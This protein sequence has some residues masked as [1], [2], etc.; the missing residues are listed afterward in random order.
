MNWAKVAEATGLKNGATALARFGQIKKRIG[1]TSGAASAAPGSTSGVTSSTP[2]KI[3][4]GTNAS[5]S[6]VAKPRGRPPGKGVKGKAR[7]EPV[8]SESHDEHVEAKTEQKAA[9]GDDVKSDLPF[10]DAENA[11]GGDEMEAYEQVHP[12][13]DG[14]AYAEFG[15]EHNEEE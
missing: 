11:Q 8:K 4:S 7:S 2:T 14:A 5:P 12:S 9:D 6:K 15:V 1:W 10:Y 3:G 13:S